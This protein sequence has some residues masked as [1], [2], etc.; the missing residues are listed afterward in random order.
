MKI[1]KLSYCLLG[2]L[3][4][5]LSFSSCEKVID[6]EVGEVSP[7]VVLV[8]RPECDSLVNVYLSHSSFFLED[9]NVNREIPDATVK[10]YVG[11]AVY[12]GTY[13]QPITTEYSY[14]PVQGY[15]QF[16]VRPQPGDSLYV[17][18]TIPGFDGTVSAG[19]RI[20]SMPNV[21]L[22]DYVLERDQYTESTLYKLRF[23]I[24][25]GVDKEYYS[26]SL[27]YCY[28]M[29][30]IDSNTRYW[31]TVNAFFD[32]LFFTSDD[33]IV[34]NTDI[35]TVIDGDDGSFAGYDMNFTNEMFKDNEHIF[36]IEFSEYSYGYTT[37]ELAE[38]P[39]W[40]N[41][42][43]FSPDLYKYE[44]TIE[45]QNNSDDF[46]SEP[47]QVLCNING[48]IGVFGGLSKRMMR[49]PVATIKSK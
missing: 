38:M 13:F 42:K 32:G 23:K 29:A 16:N 9:Y 19:T 25:G 22:V 44:Q 31:D 21:E 14:Y 20:P 10:L 7:Y 34:N 26:V 15:Y 24:K 27:S 1:K 40:L 37:L 30:E 43:S 33:A 45:A 18:A 12:N 8:S 3:S 6:F 17:E 11:D 48:G 41:V 28:Q 4:F 39:V 2:T 46:F 36:T 47:V 5:L 49:L 35:G